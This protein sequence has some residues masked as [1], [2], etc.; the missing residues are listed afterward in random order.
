MTTQV[1]NNPFIIQRSVSVCYHYTLSFGS[2][3]IYKLVPYAAMIMMSAY[4]S[5]CNTRFAPTLLSSAEQ[6]QPE[7][8]GKA[9]NAY[10]RQ[11]RWAI[12]YNFH[13]QILSA[14]KISGLPN[15]S[16]HCHARGLRRNH[17]RES[18]GAVLRI[19]RGSVR[20]RL[21][22]SVSAR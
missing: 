17:W 7:S 3:Y 19:M 11:F 13:A 22:T 16:L 15:V 6:P 18:G 8:Y 1:P 10:T 9:F 20:C 2:Q 5:D 4:S 12:S 14:D 21:Y